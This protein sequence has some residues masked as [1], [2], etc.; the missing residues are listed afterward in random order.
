[1][2][3]ARGR[4][5]ASDADREQVVDTVKAAFVQGRLTKDELDLRAGQALTARTY[6]E[7]VAATAAIPA[8]PAGPAA[9]KPASET[10]PPP[11]T[12]SARGTRPRRKPARVRDGPPSN[13]MALKCGLGLSTIVL[14]A[15][16]AATLHTKNQNLFSGTVVLLIA[17]FLALLVAMANSVA[18][19]Y[20]NESSGE[21]PGSRRVTD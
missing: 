21:I 7:L 6:A 20:E 13:H 3:A 12:G 15:M 14:P 18:S 10:R 17:Y 11:E 9:A 8:G 19:R 1:M 2:T 16:I 4:L 5:R